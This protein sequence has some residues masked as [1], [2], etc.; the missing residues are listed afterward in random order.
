MTDILEYS[1]V[2]FPR[3][4]FSDELIA[5]LIGGRA[6]GD[7][8]RRR[9][10]DRQAPVHRAADDRR[11]TSTSSAPTT[12]SATHAMRE[13]GDAI[14]ELAAVNI[15]A[16]DLLF[17][18]FGV[19]RFG[20]VVFYDYD[21]IDYLTDCQFRRI[22][23]P[24]PGYD[25]MSNDVWY[26][27]GPKDIF[28]EE[29]ATFLLTDART[30]ECFM[31]YHADLLEPGMV[32]GDAARDPLRPPGRS[33]VLP[34]GRPLRASGA[35]SARAAPSDRIDAPDPVPRNDACSSPPFAGVPACDRSPPSAPRSRRRAPRRGDRRGRRMQ[36]R[37][38]QGRRGGGEEHHRLPAQR[39]AH[40]HPLRRRRGAHA[41][42]RR[43]PRRR[44]TRSPRRPAVR[45]T[46]GMMELRGK[47]MD[48]QL[49]PRRQSD[50]ARRLPAVRRAASR[51]AR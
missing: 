19:T 8:V 37:A 23:A 26:P 42:A 22:P 10:R 40:R 2:A 9:P 51:S 15:F 4:R 36:Q 11:S 31:Y 41:D 12:R 32:A 48:L 43:R 39:R 35:V 46:N 47:G 28:P 17:K 7:R 3:E 38:Q 30:R 45:Y 6:V 24:P 34:G 27:V 29:F 18:N 20:R 25:E 1:D 16:G 50:A 49:D 5:E 13:Y 14:K 21:E 44:S 33:A